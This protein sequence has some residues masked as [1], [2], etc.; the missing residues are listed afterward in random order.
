MVGGKSDQPKRKIPPFDKAKHEVSHA[1]AKRM[2]KR[3]KELFG[4]KCEFGAPLVYGGYIFEKILAQKDCK[5]IR[6]YPGI[7]DDGKHTL[8]FCGVNSNGDDILQGII[9]DLPW[10]CPPFCSSGG[11]LL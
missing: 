10:R 3:F 8:L 9:G 6:F 2:R 1:D 4:E 7:G 11:I 5:G